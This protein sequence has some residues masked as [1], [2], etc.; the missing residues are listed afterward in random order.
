MRNNSPNPYAGLT[1]DDWWQPDDLTDA[2]EPVLS[3]AQVDRFIHD[4]FVPVTGL[5]PEALVEQ[6]LQ[7]VAELHPEEKVVANKGGFS[8]MPWTH[9]GEASPNLGLN[10]MTIHPRALSAVAQLL[11]VAPIDVRLSQSHVISRYGHVIRRPGEPRDGTIAGDQDIHVDYG[12]NTIMVPP[13]GRPEAVACLCYYSDVDESGGATHFVKAAPGEL[14]TYKPGTFNPPN[15]VL[16]TENGS[17]I[18]NEGPRSPEK[19]AK[20]YQD[21][22]PIYYKP[23]T[24][25]LYRL[26]AWHRGTP[27]AAGKVRYSHH[28][29]WRRRDAEWVNWQSGPGSH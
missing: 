27:A 22:K 28:H 17:A 6:V 14:T 12:N 24:C 19:T 3:E 25:V 15:F 29:V 20:R 23:G 9:K 1:P 13:R 11:D 10:H 4:G 26:D 18:T 8:E 2:D 16:G 5:W 21:E 7:E